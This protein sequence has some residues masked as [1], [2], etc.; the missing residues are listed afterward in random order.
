MPAFGY[1]WLRRPDLKLELALYFGLWQ[2]IGRAGA[3]T[4]AELAAD[5]IEPSE[6]PTIPISEQD[7]RYRALRHHAGET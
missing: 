2:R 7:A 5:G 4:T 1:Y 6:R 3:F